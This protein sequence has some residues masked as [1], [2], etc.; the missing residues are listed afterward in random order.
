VEQGCFGGALQPMVRQHVEPL[1]FHEAHAL[2]FFK[3][4]RFGLARS[5]NANGYLPNAHQKSGLLHLRIVRS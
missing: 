4:L 2:V 1:R 3:P 5:L